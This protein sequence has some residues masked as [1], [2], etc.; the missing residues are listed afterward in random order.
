[1][2]GEADLTLHQHGHVLSAKLF[3]NSGCKQSM[4]AVME[5]LAGR[6]FW[7][8]LVQ[9]LAQIRTITKTISGQPCMSIQVLNISKNGSPPWWGDWS[10][11]PMRKGW[12]FWACL[13]WRRLRGDRI[14]VYL[15]GGCQEDGARFFSAVPSDRPRGNGNKLKHRKFQLNMR[16]NFFP[17][18]V[19]AHRNRL[20]RDA[21]ES[22]SLEIFKTRLD[23]VLCSLL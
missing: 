8:S 23:V 9:P 4:A 13:A 1:M 21:V 17:L 2:D 3:R 12:G 16:K 7:R 11:S 10:I 22:P 20:P 19:M 15:K 5:M 18:R 14:N 6:D